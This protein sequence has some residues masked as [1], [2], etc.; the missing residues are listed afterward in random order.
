MTD[1]QWTRTSGDEAGDAAADDLSPSVWDE[2][3]MVASRHSVMVSI[4]FSPYDTEPE[5]LP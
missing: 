2:L 3:A 4:T 1:Q 5:E